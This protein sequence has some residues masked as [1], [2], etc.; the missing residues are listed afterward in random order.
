[1]KLL[2]VVLVVIM[3][4]VSF[5]TLTSCKVASPLEDYT[6]ILISYG[7]PGQMKDPVAGTEVTAL[8][9][10][11]DKTVTGSAGC[12][13]YGG[14]YTLDGLSLSFPES[15]ISTMLACTNDAFNQQE[16]A[17]LKILQKADSFEMDHGNLIIHS[18]N[19]QLNFRRAA[20]DET[21]ITHWGQ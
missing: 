3:L 15:I 18:G 9:S 6:W 8:F 17:Y 5:L 10:S 19:D 21:T 1:M 7:Q 11:K 4:P 14:K 20:A 12:N 16:Q 13:S 2:T